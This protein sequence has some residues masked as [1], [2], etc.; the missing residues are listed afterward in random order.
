MKSNDVRPDGAEEELRLDAPSGWSW[1][2][3]LLAGLYTCLIPLI[4]AVL[5]LFGSAS[6]GVALVP[7]ALLWPVGMVVLVGGFLCVDYLVRQELRFDFHSKR[8][9]RRTIVMDK[10]RGIENPVWLAADGVKAI[11][12]HQADVLGQPWEAV[13][14]DM[15]GRRVLVFEQFPR[16]VALNQYFKRRPA[17]LSPLQVRHLLERLS[18]FTGAE[19][20]KIRGFS[21][22]KGA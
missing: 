8:V 22:P 4:L 7:L 10:P 15:G 9:L 3:L 12:H 16:L 17:E 18:E 1:K 20:M 6:L 11:H 13:Y 14:L 5:T 19:V 21:A 2:L